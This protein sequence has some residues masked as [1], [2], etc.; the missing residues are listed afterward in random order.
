M[1]TGGWDRVARLWSIHDGQPEAP[2]LRHDGLLR[3]LAISPDG[4]SILTGSYDRTAQLWDKLTSKPIGPA[5]RHE[6]Q[7]WFVV[8]SPDGKRVLSGGQENSAHLWNLT[9]SLDDPIDRIELALRVDTGMT[10][11]DDG[12][13]R[14]LDNSGWNE[15]RSR[16]GTLAR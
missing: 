5:Y 11:D 16:L 15:C 10:L 7:V 2:P 12:S 8:F 4:R 9:P 14:V 6:S 1:I 13:L 3:S